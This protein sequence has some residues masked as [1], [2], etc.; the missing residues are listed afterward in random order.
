MRRSYE[1]V[2]AFYCFSVVVA[3]S[4]VPHTNLLWVNGVN[5]V[6]MRLG[7]QIGTNPFNASGETSAVL[8]E[9]QGTHWGFL[10]AEIVTACPHAKLALRLSVL[11]LIHQDMAQNK[12]WGCQTP[13]WLNF[14]VRPTGLTPALCLTQLRG[15]EICIFCLVSDA[16]QHWAQTMPFGT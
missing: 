11:R 8:V 14:P 3:V 9:D 15:S 7:H 5:L 1:C 2:K 6:S 13:V 16:H 4:P 12:V 10:R